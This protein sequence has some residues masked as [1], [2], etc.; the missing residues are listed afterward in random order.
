[1]YFPHLTSRRVESYV[2]RETVC[3]YEDDCVVPII[4]PFSE[5]EESVY[6]NTSLASMVSNLVGANKRFILRVRTLND[7]AALRQANGGSAF[8]QL[9]IYGLDAQGQI[10]GA[11]AGIQLAL[12]HSGPANVADRS[13]IVY[14]IIMPAAAGL[15]SFR[16]RIPQEKQVPLAD[17]FAAQAT[18]SDYPPR[19]VFSSDACFTFRDAGFPGFGDFT[20]LESSFRPAGGANQD[21]VTA[22]VHLTEED[23]QQGLLYINHFTTTP[24]E[25]ADNGLRI[26]T[27]ISKA[28]SQAGRFHASSGV[29]L[30]RQ[31][32]SPPS[33]TS[34]AVLKQAGMMHHIDLMHEILTR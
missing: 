1:M 10:P 9:C 8:D 12:F 22:A 28:L 24:T 2:I 13:D 27:T 21:Y 16:R 4:R 18:N 11:A 17:A 3:R 33:C 31:K 25:E 6:S 34:L 7:V 30:L 15:Q 20:I 14:H 32:H 5:D 29:A 19:E 26:C 23:R